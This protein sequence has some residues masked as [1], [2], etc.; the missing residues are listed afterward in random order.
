VTEKFLTLW[1][2]FGWFDFCEHIFFHG[3]PV[4]E[5]SLGDI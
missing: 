3:K 5:I 2:F 4:K 1:Q